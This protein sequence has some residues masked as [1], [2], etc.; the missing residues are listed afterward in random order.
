MR[1]PIQIGLT[2]VA[3][4][5]FGAPARTDADGGFVILCHASNPIA[6]LSGSSLRKALT[7]ETKQWSN[8]AVVQVGIT[9]LDSRELGSLADAAGMTP[10]DL[11]SRIQQQV[12]KGEMRRPI[13]LHSSAECVGLVRVSP[14]GICAAA[15]GGAL[16]VEV[17]IVQ[18]R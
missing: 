4:G 14:G 3:L 11:L 16:P 8:G 15:A 10:P 6:N 17:K 13:L 7:G 12:F 2:I 5:L 1:R 18:V 9:P